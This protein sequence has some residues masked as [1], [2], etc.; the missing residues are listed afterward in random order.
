VPGCAGTGAV[1]P[2][3]GY[4]L[5]FQNPDYREDNRGKPDESGKKTYFIPIILAENPTPQICPLNTAH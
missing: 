3:Q 5:Y 1:G 2:W 4:G